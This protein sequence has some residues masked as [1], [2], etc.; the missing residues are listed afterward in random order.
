MIGAA[1]MRNLRACIYMRGILAV[2]AVKNRTVWVA[3]SFAGLPE[4]DETLYPA[5]KATPTTGSMNFAH[6][7]MK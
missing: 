6:R 7:S 1:R 2:H 5:I 4:P 3:D